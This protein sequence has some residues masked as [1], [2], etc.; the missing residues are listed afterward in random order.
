MNSSKL[1]NN[2]MEIY[3]GA[4]FALI[5]KVVSSFSSY[6]LTFV[7]AKHFDLS[8]SGYTF[9]AITLLYIFSTVSRVGLDNVVV[10]YVSIFKSGGEN[11]VIFVSVVFSMLLVLFVSILISVFLCFL[12]YL[13]YCFS[14]L[15][16]DVYRFYML[17]LC[18]IPGL[19]IVQLIACIYQ[20][21]KKVV[22]SNFLM[23]GIF[24]TILSLFIYFDEI[25]DLP[26]IGW[27]FIIASYISTVLSILLMLS[28]LH[29][30]VKGLKLNIA[31]FIHKKMKEIYRNFIFES[32][33]MFPLVVLNLLITWWSQIVLALFSDSETISYF[34][35]A[36]R[37]SMILGFLILAANS[38]SAPKFSVYYKERNMEK[39]EETLFSSVRFVFVISMPIIAVIFICPEYVLGFFGKQYTN[40]SDMFI[41]LCVA[42]MFNLVTGTVGQLLMMSDNQNLMKRSLVC[43]FILNGILSLI[44]VNDFGGLGVAYAYAISFIV[45]NLLAAYYVYV[46]FKLNVFCSL[47]LRRKNV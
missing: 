8:V 36:Q 7:I 6:I 30:E 2:R 42:Q 25:S 45:Q 22:V 47:L 18:S 33:S 44:L 11:K 5:S 23:S 17:V 40:V 9:F 4:L 10:K 37:T 27:C 24:P 19:A 31:S 1:L 46:K 21:V 41:V 32:M 26:T 15:E 39:I 14:I 34:S 28:F 13:I 20:G 43:S 16:L 29:L 3:L 35:V 12:L 38:I